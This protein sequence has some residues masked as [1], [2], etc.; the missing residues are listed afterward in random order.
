MVVFFMIIII[1]VVGSDDDIKVGE[2]DVAGCI[3][4]LYE[5]LQYLIKFCLLYHAAW[6]NDL[7]ARH[8]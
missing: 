4:S 8:W 5:R 1:V 3:A 7:S 6:G 2:N